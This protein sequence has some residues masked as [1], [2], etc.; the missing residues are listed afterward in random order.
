[1]VET[2]NARLVLQYLIL[3]DS[4]R[5]HAFLDMLPVMEDTSSTKMISKSGLTNT[6]DEK[7]N[8]GWIPLIDS[9]TKWANDLLL[10]YSPL[11]SA[12]A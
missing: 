5:S 3:L 1:M 4:I 11:T 6:W 12:I 8:R 2:L 9:Y 7:N 10:G